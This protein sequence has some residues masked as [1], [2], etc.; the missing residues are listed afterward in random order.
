[1]LITQRNTHGLQPWNATIIMEN[2]RY[3]SHHLPE[4]L[5]KLIGQPHSNNQ[6]ETVIFKSE[7]VTSP[8]AYISSRTIPHNIL[9]HSSAAALAHKDKNVFQ[10]IA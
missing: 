9:D 7:L 5:I 2:Y 8:A 4:L 10:K 1:M 3:M 6:F